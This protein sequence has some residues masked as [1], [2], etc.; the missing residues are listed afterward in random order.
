MVPLEVVHVPEK[1]LSFWPLLKLILALGATFTTDAFRIKFPT[2]VIFAL[3]S[4]FA[5]AVRV[6]L[7]VPTDVIGET[8]VIVPKAPTEVTQLIEQVGEPEV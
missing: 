4:I 1:P 8:T 5:S 3:I 7:P 6:K 2:R